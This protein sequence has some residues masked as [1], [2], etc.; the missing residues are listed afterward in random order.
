[1]GWPDSACYPFIYRRKSWKEVGATKTTGGGGVI[2]PTLGIR[3]LETPEIHHLD[4]FVL[5]TLPIPD[6]PSNPSLVTVCLVMGS[7]TRL[8]LGLPGLKL[9][10]CT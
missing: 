5:D 6:V 8:K 4:P 9:E 7:L 10:G 3:N 2:V 1:M